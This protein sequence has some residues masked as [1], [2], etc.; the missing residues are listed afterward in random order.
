MKNVEQQPSTDMTSMA[1]PNAKARQKDRLDIM[2][3]GKKIDQ[4]HQQRLEAAIAAP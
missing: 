3:E 4:A 1:D 2:K